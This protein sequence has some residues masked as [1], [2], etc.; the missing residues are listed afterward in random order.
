MTLCTH[1]RSGRDYEY[2]LSEALLY[3]SI[4]NLARYIEQ[5][6]TPPVVPLLIEAREI[7]AKQYE[8]ESQPAAKYL[9]R[10]ARSGEYDEHFATKVVLTA[11][12]RGIEMAGEA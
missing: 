6:E 2:K 4:Q 12:E 8:A 5:H 1:T 7:C 10:Q 11:L 9:A 3:D